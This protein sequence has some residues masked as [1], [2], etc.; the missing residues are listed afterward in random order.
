LPEYTDI[1]I[2]TLAFMIQWPTITTLIL[3]PFVIGMYYKLARREERQAL[4]K[5]P[6]E[7]REYMERTPMFFPGLVPRHR[8]TTRGS[9]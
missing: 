5:Y 9:R 1:L 8:Q 7:Y 4:E 6:D 3:W 2:I